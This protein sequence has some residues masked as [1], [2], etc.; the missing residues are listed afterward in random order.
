[1]TKVQSLNKPQNHCR[2]GILDSKL[3]A[4]FLSLASKIHMDFFLVAIWLSEPATVCKKEEE[5][6]EKGKT[7]QCQGVHR[8]YL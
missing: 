5:E 2:Q 8:K 4:A 3:D 7:S 6:E 1:M